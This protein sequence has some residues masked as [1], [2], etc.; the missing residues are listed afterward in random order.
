[1]RGE[2]LS[3]VTK[4][5]AGRFTEEDKAEQKEIEDRKLSPDTF[6]LSRF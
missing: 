5:G 4:A 3:E 6:Q 1:L 2:K